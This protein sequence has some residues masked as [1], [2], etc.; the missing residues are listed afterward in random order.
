MK[1]NTDGASRGNLRRCSYGFCLRNRD[2]DLIY[3]HGE[4][5]HEGTNI[6]AEAIAI[7]ETLAHC[8][9]VGITHICLETDSLVL[10]K[11]LTKVWKVPWNIAITVK[12]T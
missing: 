2:V 7:K 3:A 1:C 9:T 12:D 11:V 5:I 8:V 10:I 6:E 4:E